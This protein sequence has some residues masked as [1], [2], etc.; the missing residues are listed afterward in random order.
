MKMKFKDVPPGAVFRW[1]TD[2]PM[3]KLLVPSTAGDTPAWK[4]NG[5]FYYYV[6]IATK[7]DMDKEVEFIK[8]PEAK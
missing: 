8:A 4:Y 1:G 7:S 2:I 6:H 5:N 3:I